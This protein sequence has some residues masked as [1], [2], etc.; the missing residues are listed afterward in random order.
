[1]PVKGSFC[2]KRYKH[3]GGYDT[4]LRKADSN[5]NIILAS[6]LQNQLAPADRVNDSRTDLSDANQSCEHSHSDNQSDPP[7]DRPSTERDP[8]D[9]LV[10]WEP[11]REV[12]EDNTYPV[13]AEEEDY[14]GGGKELERL[15]RI[16]KN[17]GICARMLGAQ[18]PQKDL[19]GK[20][21]LP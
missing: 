17:A 10:R 16:M 12:L 18:T 19:P 11:E 14:P 6:T 3:A 13:A 7:R 8:P 2:C 9:D 5:I 21:S 1:M 4:R 20:V 15:K